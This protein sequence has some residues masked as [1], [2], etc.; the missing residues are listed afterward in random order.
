MIVTQYS[1]LKA[2]C[3]VPITRAIENMQFEKVKEEIIN[4]KKKDFMQSDTFYVSKRDFL[5]KIRSAMQ[6]SI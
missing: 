1:Y 2:E 5:Q 3:S 6:K 4:S